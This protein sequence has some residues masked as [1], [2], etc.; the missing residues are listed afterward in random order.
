MWILPT[1]SRPQQCAAVL[2]RI[3]DAGCSSSGIVFVNG[4]ASASSYFKDDIE[5]PDGWSVH[6]SEENIGALG[7]LNKVF[8]LYPNEPFYGFVGD[9]EF[10]SEAPADWDQQLIKAAGDWNISH[11]YD[12]LHQGKRAQGYLCIGGRLARALGYLAIPECW[13]YYGLDDMW[14]AL[15]SSKLCSETTFYDI[16]IEH[17]HPATGKIQMDACYELGMSNRDIDQQH[18]FHWMRTHLPLVAQRIQEARATR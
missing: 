3:K 5:M 18:Y 7:A 6:V 13:H 12:N 8:E 10:L 1:L 11:G 4:W 9:D 15:R 17:R 2:K 14:E 16:K